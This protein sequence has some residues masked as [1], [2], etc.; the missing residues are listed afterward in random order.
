MARQRIL[1]NGQWADLLKPKCDERAII[2]HYTLSREDLD[3]V[4]GKRGDH[5]RLGF[6]VL[7]CRI[8]QTG[9]TATGGDDLPD[10]VI[11]FVARQLD[12]NPAIHG[13]YARR[14]ETRREYVGEIVRHLALST[15]SR[16]TGRT[17]IAW[18]VGVAA[19]E[20]S[21]VRLAMLVR[22]IRSRRILLQSLAVLD[23]IIR[24]ARLRAEKIMIC[25]LVGDL[26]DARL[27]ALD[28]LLEPV[29]EKSTRPAGVA[30]DRQC[31]PF[32][33][34]H[35]RDGRAS[36]DGAGGRHRPGGG[37]AGSHKYAVAAGR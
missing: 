6:A 12:I 4:A 37:E 18:L 23:M 17:L 8:R 3:Q 5:N 34:Q 30:E 32:G 11:L 26:D 13:R 2:R 27:A 1:T 14:D 7:L 31:I 36:A 25:A 10:A 16:P 15:L 21:P 28:R 24:R 19:N 22:E 20:R 29:P 35:G 9:Q 33:P